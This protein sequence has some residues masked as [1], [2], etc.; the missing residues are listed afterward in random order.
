MSTL[1]RFINQVIYDRSRQRQI[2]KIKKESMKPGGTVNFTVI[3]LEHLSKMTRHK[4]REGYLE[5]IGAHK[6]TIGTVLM[7]LG[8]LLIFTKC[9]RNLQAKPHVPTKAV[10][11]IQQPIFYE[12][13]TLISSVKSL[14]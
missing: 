11:T 4:K 12:E 13:T 9:T 14:E 5:G 1:Q 6:K 7:I 10:A 3:Q 8:F 2:R